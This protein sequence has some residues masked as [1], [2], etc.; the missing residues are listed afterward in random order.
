MLLFLFLVLCGYALWLARVRTREAIECMT[1]ALMRA[2]IEGLPRTLMGGLS[3]TPPSAHTQ[4]LEWARRNRHRG[5]SGH[6]LRV[7]MVAAGLS[8]LTACSGASADARVRTALDLLAEVVDPAFA[9]AM[10]GCIAPQEVAAAQAEAG[11]VTAAQASAVIAK[12][13]ARCGQLRE[14][15]E[16]IRLHRDEAQRLIEAGDLDRAEKLLEQIRADWRE[17][18][19]AAT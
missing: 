5:W 6:L 15:F 12:V 9:L 4:T 18:P 17:L 16:T 19:G 3:R 10:D 1:D 11:R 2:P 7:A 13:R 14:S 8:L